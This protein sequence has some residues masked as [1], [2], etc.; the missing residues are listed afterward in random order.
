MLTDLT[1]KCPPAEACRDAFDRMSKATI[2]MCLNSTGFGSQ[3]RF[4]KQ[5]DISPIV[6]HHFEQKI[7]P[8]PNFSNMPSRPPPQ[9]DDNW[10][11]LFPD[12]WLASDT[13]ASG[14]L[15]GQWQASNLQ[16]TTQPPPFSP[17]DSSTMSES[18]KSIAT[19]ISVPQQQSRQQYDPSLVPQTNA[20]LMNN[21]NALPNYDMYDFDFLMNNDNLNTISAF[22]GDS[23]L[24]LGFDAHHDWADG[25]NEQLPD[26]FGGFFFGGP[27]SEGA[28]MDLGYAAT[29]EFGDGQSGVTAGIW[30]GGQEQ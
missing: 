26:L 1:D 12:T 22:T 7:P 30:N 18:T 21:D 27:T 11:D 16:Y 20:P 14:S 6:Q 10:K 5:H 3:V 13:R 15:Q 24:N 9:L 29:S 17:S 2:K 4:R 23:G 8:Q 28:P 25:V 19:S